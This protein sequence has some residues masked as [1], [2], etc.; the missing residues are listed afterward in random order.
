MRRWIPR[1]LPLAGL[2]IVVAGNAWCDEIRFADAIRNISDGGIVAEAGP[3]DVLVFG[4]GVFDAGGRPLAI[5]AES[6]RIDETTLILSHAD[7]SVPAAIEGPAGI[8]TSGRGGSSWGCRNEAINLPLIGNMTIQVCNLEGEP[9]GQ[10]QTGTGGRQGAAGGAIEI[11]F[12]ELIGEAS[13]VV[14]G[15]GQKGGQ[16]QKGGPGGPGGRGTNGQNRAG[17]V[18]CGNQNSRLNGSRG[19]NGGA[20]GI[21]GP[22]GEGGRGSS[23]VVDVPNNAR[24][25]TTAASNP[26]DVYATIALVVGGSYVDEEAPRLH[27]ISVGGRGGDG[28][29]KG[30]PGG[31]GG[32]GDAGKSSHCG[33]GGQP[34][35]PGDRGPDGQAGPVGPFGPPGEIIRV[36]EDD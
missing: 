4:G 5:L 22:G 15:N 10:G 11:A 6:I 7:S 2:T 19:G 1:C 8:G 27:V 32:G 28:G 13:L 33:G 20:G 36:P 16:G 35:A 12:E 26:E 30:S 34:G 24:I 3:G 31:P 25:T 29:P 21:G 9:G 23:I 17:D 14:V 18:F